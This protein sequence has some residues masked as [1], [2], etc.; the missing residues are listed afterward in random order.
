MKYFKLYFDNHRPDGLVWEVAY[1]DNQHRYITDHYSE[2]FI[3]VPMKTVY[4]GKNA[5]EPKAVMKGKCSNMQ[6]TGTKLYIT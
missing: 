4:Y 5:K 3:S 1:S 2:V 6:G